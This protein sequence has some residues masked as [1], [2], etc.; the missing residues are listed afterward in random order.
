MS[1]RLSTTFSALADPT[2]RA[3]LARLATG[4]AS[5]TE[6]AEPFAMSLP[7]ISKHLKVLERAG[8]IARG[9][10]AQW[11][12]RRLEAGPLKDAAAY[13]EH[14]RGFWDASLELYL[15]QLQSDPV[16]QTPDLKK[17]SKRG[18]RK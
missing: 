5:V 13:L 1:D 18:R 8:L 2:R 15:Q 16:A 9:Q 3:I 14:Y 4:A 17:E 11:R 10:E 6:L 7:A 12:P